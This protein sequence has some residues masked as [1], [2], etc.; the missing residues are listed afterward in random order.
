MWL[1]QKSQRLEERRRDDDDSNLAFHN[2]PISSGVKKIRIKISM[3][4]QLN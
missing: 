1:L 4:K 2:D 3:N